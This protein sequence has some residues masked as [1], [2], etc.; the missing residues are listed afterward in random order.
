MLHTPVNESVLEKSMFH[1]VEKP[2]NA[3]F[4]RKPVMVPLDRL[5]NLAWYSMQTP[6]KSC[7]AYF[8]YCR[9]LFYVIRIQELLNN[10]TTGRKLPVRSGFLYTSNKS[11]PS[12]AR[13]GYRGLFV[14]FFFVVVPSITFADQFGSQHTRTRDAP[15]PAATCFGTVF[16]LWIMILFCVFFFFITYDNCFCVTPGVLAASSNNQ[17]VLL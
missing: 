13:S 14:C 7:T 4:K 10:F 5:S 9:L 8:W 1:W 6:Y 17:C 16:S 12:Y 11:A 3:W 2:Y 15:Q